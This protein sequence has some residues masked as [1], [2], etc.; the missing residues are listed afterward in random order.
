VFAIFA[1]SI[2]GTGNN[3]YAAGTTFNPLSTNAPDGQNATFGVLAQ[4]NLTLGSS[5]NQSAMAAFGNF[6]NT[7]N[8][9][10][11][12]RMGSEP[13]PTI[14]GVATRLLAQK[15]T[16]G[17]GQFEVT[18]D[19]V[20][21]GDTSN[22]KLTQTGPGQ[23]QINGSNGNANEITVNELQ[24]A[25]LTDFKATK[26]PVNGYFT[27]LKDKITSTNACLAGMYNLSEVNKVSYTNGS[28][29]GV[30][31][32]KVNYF[33]WSDI[34]NVTIWSEGYSGLSESSPL[35]VRVPNGTTT[36]ND[37]LQFLDGHTDTAPYVLWDL[38]Q[39]T[40]TVTLNNFRGGAIYAPNAD[41]IFNMNSSINTQVLGKNIV[42]NA[43]YDGQE[44][45]QL[46][47]G[48]KLPC[49]Q[50]TPTVTPVSAPLSLTKQVD[51]ATAGSTF[52]QKFSFTLSQQSGDI[53]AVTLPSAT[54]AKN[55]A[56]G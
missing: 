40:G 39:V 33:N 22:L 11:N 7:H 28:V 54:T 31:N 32:G 51:G 23:V 1:A 53:S 19:F 10:G 35:V 26:S 42:F 18:R 38:S 37:P 3:A 21:L 48:V 6:Q 43:A 36:I 4:G 56:N 14:D 24:N 27:G 52:N 17:N 25:K 8:N 46:N 29:S 15:F 20:K 34:S 13:I 44:V 55:D 47:F 41:L 5:H 2:G 12:T 49:G 16:G 50:S 30:A 9:N 45:H